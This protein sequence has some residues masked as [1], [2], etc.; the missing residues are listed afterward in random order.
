[1]RADNAYYRRDFAGYCRERGWDYSVSVT[2]GVYH[3]P[4][5]DVLEGL[6]ETAWEDIG[7]RESATRVRYRPG[8]WKMRDYVVVRRLHDGP[9]RCLLPSH[10][11]SYCPPRPG[12]T[13]CVR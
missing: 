8:G 12:H 7:L 5:L 13:N 9:Q 11:T 1:M 4:I 10:N 6:D 2:H 3:R